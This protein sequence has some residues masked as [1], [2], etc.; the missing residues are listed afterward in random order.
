MHELWRDINPML[1]AVDFVLDESPQIVANG[2][3]TISG[4]QGGKKPFP[5]SAGRQRPHGRRP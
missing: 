1:N 5:A 4:L 3:L 2:E